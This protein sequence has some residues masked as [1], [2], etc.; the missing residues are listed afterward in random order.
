M[1]S[2]NPVLGR[3][4]N[5]RGFASMNPGTTIQ[6]DAPV[7]SPQTLENLYNAPAASSLRTGRMTIDDVVTRTGILFGIL[8]ITGA[9]AWTLNLGGGFLMIGFLG[10]FVLAMVNTFSK[11]VR[12]ALIMAYAAFEGLALG[13]LS[14]VYNTIYPGIVSQAIIGTLAAFVGVLFAY[15]SG[16]VRVTPKFTRMVMGAAI[17]YLV[18]GL[19]SMFA[20]FAHVGGGMGLY[21]VS[22]LGLLLA[23]AGVAIASIFL[24]LDFDQIQKGV[25]A[26]LPEVESWR[27]GFGLMVTIVWLY[28]EVLRL[29]S[30]LRSGD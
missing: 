21:G 26:G 8:V 30:I 11:T 16:R 1:Q 23:L 27:A 7:D 19:V 17:G 28:M 10:G 29:L 5:Q 22:G 18:L 6:H 20:S 12:P 3:A 24:I 4:F 9:A 15:K 13:T 14:H 25:N 2:S